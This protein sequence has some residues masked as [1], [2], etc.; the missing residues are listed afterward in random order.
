MASLLKQTTR[1]SLFCRYARNNFRAICRSA[2]RKGQWARLLI[3]ENRTMTLSELLFF[4]VG[5]PLVVLLLS[6]SIWATTT[7][8]R[9]GS[10]LFPI[11]PLIG[12]ALLWRERPSL[13]FDDIQ[14]LCLGGVLLALCL[15]LPLWF[16]ILVLFILLEIEMSGDRKLYKQDKAPPKGGP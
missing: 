14:R 5:M 2:P 7:L 1:Q 4:F 16:G 6:V 11:G 10:W 9:R 3:P 8:L 13:T 15:F 12:A